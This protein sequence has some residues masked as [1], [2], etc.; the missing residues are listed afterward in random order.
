MTSSKKI[1]IENVSKEL[2][3]HFIYTEIIMGKIYVIRG[4]AVRFQVAGYLLLVAGEVA[5]SHGAPRR[6]PQEVFEVQLL[7]FLK[8]HYHPK[9]NVHQEYCYHQRFYDDHVFVKK[10]YYIL[11]HQ[12]NKFLLKLKARWRVFLMA[13]KWEYTCKCQV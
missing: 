13:T 4:L 12:N 2:S 3:T 11:K 7:P 5:S 10:N 8:R 9:S 1:S 6:P